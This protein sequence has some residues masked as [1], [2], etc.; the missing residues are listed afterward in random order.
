MIIRTG[1]AD[2]VKIHFA[3][4]VPRN[5]VDQSRKSVAQ[6]I[7]SKMLDCAWKLNHLCSPSFHTMANVG[8]MVIKLTP[9]K[10]EGVIEIPLYQ[11]GERI[12]RQAYPLCDEAFMVAT[13]I[14]SCQR[15]KWSDNDLPIYMFRYS[16]PYITIYRAWIDQDL[17]DRVQARR[18][19]TPETTLTVVSRFRHPRFHDAKGGFNIREPREREQLMR[20][21]CEIDGRVEWFDC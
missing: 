10:A 1:L 17:L 14:S 5:D 21:L 11:V 15:W 8:V 16:D 12:Q 4:G 9:E 3:H 19:A 13:A 18:P 6:W 7:T 20:F 2:S